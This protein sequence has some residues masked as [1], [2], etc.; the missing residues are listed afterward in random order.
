MKELLINLLRTAEANL[1][2]SILRVDPK[3]VNKQ[4]L[5]EMNTITWII[6]HCMAHFHMHLCNK[7]EDNQI[8]L[9]EI[10]H[11]FQCLATA[12]DKTGAT[13][14]LTFAHILDCFLV[15]SKGPEC[16]IQ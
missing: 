14:Q 3:T 2:N 15:I 12:E 7:C 6:G 11:D 10:D 16:V 1:L 13:T 9:Q 5:P 4:A 8:D